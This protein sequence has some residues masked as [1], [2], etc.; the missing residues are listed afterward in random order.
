VQSVLDK[1]ISSALSV[2]TFK[3]FHMKKILVLAMLL[4]ACGNKV[5][6]VVVEKGCDATVG[7]SLTSNCQIAGPAPTP[8]A[9]PA[10][11]GLVF[12]GDEPTPPPSSYSNRGSVQVP[13]G[14]PNSWQLL[15]LNNQPVVTKTVA[16]TMTL[17]GQCRQV[18]VK[19]VVGGSAPASAQGTWYFTTNPNRFQVCLDGND[20]LVK[21]EDGVDS[22][23]NDY[24]V[25]IR[26]TTG[27]PLNYQFVGGNL[28]VCLD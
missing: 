18:N 13:S 9:G 6:T 14:T 22:L 20:V 26:S 24:Q 23:F 10:S 28:F 16:T 15:G 21:F 17:V 11:V 3:E 5:D 2:L 19:V 7:L 12:S 8:T 25:R 27:Q 1:A 4:A